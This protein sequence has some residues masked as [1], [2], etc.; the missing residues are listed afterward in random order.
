MARD[1]APAAV[2]AT[3]TA[4]ATTQDERDQLRAAVREFAA[5][6]AGQ[7]EDKVWRQ[8]TE[9]LGVTALAVPAGYGGDGFGFAEL[10]VVLE[11]LGRALTPGPFFGTVVLAGSALLCCGDE[12]A[13]SRY[14]PGIATGQTTATLAVTEAAGRW[15]A[16]GL[17]TLASQ[18]D[19]GWTITGEKCFVI[20]GASAELLLVVAGTPDGAG[21]FAVEAAGAAGLSREPLTSLDP[22]RPLARITFAGVPAELI[23]E[24]GGATAVL[25]QVQTRAT[26]ALA[27]EQVGGIQAC[28]EASTGYARERM[29]FGR[30]I[31]SFQAVKHKCADMYARGQLAA[32]AAAEAALA[33]D[34]AEGAPE[35]GLAAAVAHAVCSEA[36]M[37]VAA[38]NI[39]VHG[40]IAFTW[41]H[42]AHRYFRRAKSSQL[43]FGGPGEYFERLLLRAGV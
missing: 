31:G 24:P 36:Y 42:P 29:Q 22:S 21:L 17:T 4:A 9:Q 14:L 5:R 25:E 32:A 34:G 40:G 23:G 38:E 7:P 18:T 11:E 3:T 39:Q 33:I 19:H 26:A 16:D 41:E 15:S 27:A 2:A 6:M 10:S 37:F 1:D 35:A 13:R 20:D 28:L 8:L 30:P 43:L 12:Q